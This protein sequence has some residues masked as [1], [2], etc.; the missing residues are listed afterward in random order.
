MKNDEKVLFKREG[1]AKICFVVAVDI[2]LKFLLL[3]QLK[4]F[5]DKGYKVFAVCSP[6]KWIKDIEKEG[7]EI[8][9]I[10]IKRKAFSPI[11]DLISLFQLFF[12]F[13]K[14]K[15]DIVFTFTPKPGLLGCLAAK[16]A[17]TPVILNTI[18]GFYFHERTPYLKRKFFILIERL[19]ARC[20]DFIF[21]RNKEDFET[22]KKE[23]IIK[24]AISE[25]IGDGID[26]V[27]FDNARF[28]QEFIKE[29]KKKIGISLGIP[30]IGIVARLVKEKG[31]IELFEAHKKVIEK[32][33]DALL[34]V[35]GPDDVQKKDS[36]NP[37]IVKDFGIE[38]NVLFLG[39]RT[40]IEEIYPLLDIFVLPSFR[41]GFSH[42]IME[43]SAMA[44]PVITTDVRGCRGAIE[45]N[46]TGILIAPKNYQA[47]AEAI[48]YLLSNPDTAKKMGELGR[49][50]AKKEFDE[51]LFFGKMEE[52]IKELIN[53]KLG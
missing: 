2:T 29:K 11:S 17:E 49:I 18:F 45:P 1:N 20:S 14:E 40:D 3:S 26:I 41:E 32:F 4:F 22:A 15:F 7:I 52:K 47:L 9:K 27:K 33:P 10:T 19:A 6:G 35:V 51:R 48:M 12:Y 5:K 34:L 13:K 23:K 39:E 46:V 43:A 50:K 16:M 24:D 28:S 21:F 30:V 8:K 37:S 25:Y 31:Y 42:S 38:K 53:I 44:R 36:I